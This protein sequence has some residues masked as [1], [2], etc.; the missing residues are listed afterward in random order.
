MIPSWTAKGEK[1][2]WK[3][4]PKKIPIW[5]PKLS[6]I[7]CVKKNKITKRRLGER[8]GKAKKTR[9]GERGREREKEAVMEKVRGRGKEKEGER[10]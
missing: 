7:L 6:P 10:G 4:K 5:K 2:N 8:S 3:G 1:E 9:E